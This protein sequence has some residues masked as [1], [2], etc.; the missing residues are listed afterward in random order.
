MANYV[1]KIED[2]YEMNFFF[3][4]WDDKGKIEIGSVGNT[5]QG[6]SEV[7]RELEKILKGTR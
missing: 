6:V 5:K 1:G 3:Y 2:T 4:D 7:F